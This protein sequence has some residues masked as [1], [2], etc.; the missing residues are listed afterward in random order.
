MPF[1]DRHELAQYTVALLIP[2][3]GAALTFLSSDCSTSAVRWRRSLRKSQFSPPAFVFAIVWVTLYVA[4]GHASYLVY[5]KLDS[6]SMLDAPLVLYL[7]QCVLNHF[8]ILVLFGLQRIDLALLMI[9]PLWLATGLTAFLFADVCITAAY[10]MSAV[11]AWVSVNLY[12][13]AFLYAKNDIYTE[14]DLPR[15]EKDGKDKI[16]WQSLKFIGSNADFITQVTFTW[17]CLIKRGRVFSEKRQ[18]GH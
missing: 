18:V 15:Q 5:T 4:M 10:L 12:F 3:L 11:F 6:P 16:S 1:Q 7:T 2:I 8:Y 13:N 17:S 14:T 9:G